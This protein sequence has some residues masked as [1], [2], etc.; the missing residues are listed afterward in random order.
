[1]VDKHTHAIEAM[2]LSMSLIR[3]LAG[4]AFDQLAGGALTL[5]ETPNSHAL[6]TVGIGISRKDF[7]KDVKRNRIALAVMVRSFA[8]LMPEA[9]AKMLSEALRALN[10]GETRSILQATVKGEGKN[11][12]LAY[13]LWKRRKE[14]TLRVAYTRA[15]LAAY[16]S[17][18]KHREGRSRALKHVY[19]YR[20]THNLS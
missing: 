19:V 15:R 8:N 10:F 14:A 12:G 13:T 17:R 9:T 2:D 3:G 20:S 16:S 18:R 1:M 5:S 4:W 7:D 11:H 6:E